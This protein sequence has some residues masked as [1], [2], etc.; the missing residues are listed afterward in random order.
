[1]KLLYFAYGSNMLA[2]RV[3]QFDR[4]PEAV[5]S[6]PARLQNHE[7]VF[8][9]IGRDGSGKAN[10]RW[11]PGAEVWGGLFRVSASGLEG[12]DRAEGLGVGYRRR[13][14]FVETAQGHCEEVFL[15]EALQTQDGLRPFDWYSELVVA[16]ARELALPAHYLTSITS[17]ATLP[18][19]DLARATWERR[20]LLAD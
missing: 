19:E 14:A 9:K 4:A 16:G 7:L 1:M 8:D 12:L 11:K 6:G 2:A 13:T 15:Y 17:V 20:A 18:D 5:P 10:V 3:R